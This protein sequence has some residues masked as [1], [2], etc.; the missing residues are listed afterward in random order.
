MQTI[1]YYLILFLGLAFS[2]FIKSSE[3]PEEITTPHFHYELDDEDTIKITKKS[4]QLGKT[5]YYG[6]YKLKPNYLQA[7]KILE[8]LVNKLN[9][10]LK[11]DVLEMLGNMFA[12]GGHGLARNKYKGLGFLYELLNQEISKNKEAEIRGIINFFKGHPQNNYTEYNL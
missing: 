4:V 6:S 7:T 3:M 10:P 1:N 5:Y 8:P 11:N 12:R 9:G 2:T